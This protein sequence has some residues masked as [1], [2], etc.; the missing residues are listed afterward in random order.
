M[1]ALII[2][3]LISFL[4]T[5]H[6]KVTDVDT[7]SVFSKSMDRNIPVAVVLPSHY[8][9]SEK[10]Y[11]VLYLLHGA[12][13]NFTSWLNSPPNK[14][15]VH[16]LSDQYQVI[17]VLPDGGKR[18]FY[19]DSP[20][21]P[22]SQYST[23]IAKELQTYIDSNYR[24]FKKKEGRLIAGLSMGGH[25]AFYIASEYPELYTAA[26][27]MSGVMNLD[28]KTWMVPDSLAEEY[29]SYLKVLLGPV[30]NTNQHFFESSI[31]GRVNK[32]KAG[33]IYLSFDCG[34]EDFLI[35]TNR[36]LH[37]RLLDQKVPHVYIEKNGDHSWEYWQN[38]LPFHMLYFYGILKKNGTTVVDE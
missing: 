7:L 27:S 34:T 10:K 31:I 20:N 23:F 1:K 29:T 21:I 9:E 13:G 15:T 36:N 22:D 38:S 30:K 37:A 18:S 24:T 12:N 19:F 3:F 28:T 2:P 35:E 25:G 14:S 33:G 6:L 26:A 5:N 32:L 8:S 4:I 17:I 16:K 11:P